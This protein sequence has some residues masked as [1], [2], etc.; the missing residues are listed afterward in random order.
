MKTILTSPPPP[1]TN[2]FDLSNAADVMVRSVLQK[3]ASQMNPT[4]TVSP[5]PGAGTCLS[6]EATVSPLSKTK[7]IFI[8]SS[9]ENLKVPECENFDSSEVDYSENENT[10]IENGSKTAPRMPT[11]ISL[12][13]IKEIIEAEKQKIDI[14]D[15]SESDTDDEIQDEIPL[16]H[17]PRS[18]SVGHLRLERQDNDKNLIE[19]QL[20]KTP[21]TDRPRDVARNWEKENSDNQLISLLGPSRNLNIWIGTW[22]LNLNTA[23]NAA[24]LQNFLNVKS[25]ISKDVYIFGCQEK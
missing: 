18:A 1:T 23:V 6:R 21:L 7:S 25:A 9:D 2:V 5:F 19:N 8:G 15:F 22:N 11:T 16:N 17:R 12:D 4:R 24:H 3:V 14:N 13:R 20:P 10:T